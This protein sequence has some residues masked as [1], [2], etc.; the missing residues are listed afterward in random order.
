M[1]L[2]HDHLDRSAAA[3]LVVLCAIWGVQQVAVKVAIAGI[4]PVFQAGLR[5]VGA[6]VLV[7]IWSA[8]SGVR[9]FQRDGT[10]AAGLAAAA[11]FA[12]EFALIYWGLTYTAASRGVIFLYTAPFFV[13]LGAIWLLPQERVGAAQWLGMGLAFLGVLTLFGENLLRPA[14][15]AWIGDLMLL[16]A[17][18]L[19]AATTLVIKAS[20]LV[21]AR[22]EK[23]LLYQLAGSALFLPLVSWGLGEQGVIALTPLVL[24]SLAFQIVIVAAS[25]YLAWFWLVRHY[26]ATRLSAFSFLTPV[27]GVLAGSLLLGEPLTPAVL[28]ALTLVGSGIWLANRVRVKAA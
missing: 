5:S 28:A 12:G 7:W 17:A 14:G 26:P 16:G 3:L 21:T 19:W 15:P 25:S 24:S 20:R 2:T 22:A 10:L 11:L 18:V 23:T 27:F 6:A 8:C 4:S 13:A 1:S 9:L